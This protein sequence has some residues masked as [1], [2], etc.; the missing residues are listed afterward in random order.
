MNSTAQRRA[1]ALR[2][3]LQLVRFAAQ[4]IVVASIIGAV[5]TGRVTVSAQAPPV[6]PAGGLARYD[7]ALTTGSTV[8][9]QIQGAGALPALTIRGSDFRVSD[10]EILWNANIGNFTHTLP[11]DPSRG[12]FAESADTFPNSFSGGGT[13]AV[14]LRVD[15]SVVASLGQASLVG[16]VTF[17]PAPDTNVHSTPPRSLEFSRGGPGTPM[18]LLAREGRTNIGS[19]NQFNDKAET[20][21]LANPSS[22]DRTAIVVWD[23]QTLR[24]YYDGLLAATTTRLTTDYPTSNYRLFVAVNQFVVHSGDHQFYTGAMKALVVYD[25]ALSATEV[26]ALHGALS[27]GNPT[28]TAPSA[29]RNLRIVG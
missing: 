3:R 23:S 24:I 2:P 14:R 9:N 15:P 1:Q 5:S 22:A 13:L 7:F 11:F 20:G 18:Q 28:P 8:P 4:G 6:M 16:I 12:T 27:S 10:G 19:N 21:S 26:S 29:P 17:R 25:R